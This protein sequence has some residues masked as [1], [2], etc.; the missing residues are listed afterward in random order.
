ME[1]VFQKI[2]SYS[3]RCT[4]A[5][6]Q[7]GFGGLL[8]RNHYREVTVGGEEE[9]RENERNMLIVWKLSCVYLKSREFTIKIV[10]THR[11]LNVMV[12]NPLLTSVNT[13]RT[14]K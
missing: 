3:N 8:S 13:G 9:T 12:R 5:A 7:C 6:H 14:F 1:K 11:R 2:K 4:A 10:H